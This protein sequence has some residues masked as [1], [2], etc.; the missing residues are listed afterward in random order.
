MPDIVPEK[1]AE[2]RTKEWIIDTLLRA[3][4]MA[5]RG[6]FEEVVIIGARMDG[7]V[8][9]SASQQTSRTCRLGMV[10]L[11]KQAM[12]LGWFQSDAEGDQ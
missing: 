1:T 2:E 3:L 7:N 5:K 10:E 4:E 12:V 9:L 6:D 8:W 11:A